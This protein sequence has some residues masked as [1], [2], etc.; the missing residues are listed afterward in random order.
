MPLHVIGH[1]TIKERFA[2]ALPFNIILVGPSGVGKRRL[3]AYLAQRFARPFDILSLEPEEDD[4]GKK[5]AVNVKQV[6]SCKKF[7]ATRPFASPCKIVVIN[8]T[9][10]TNEAV[11]ALLR[12]L[13]ESSDRVRFI[14]HTSGVLPLTILS[15]CV[16]V[17]VAPLSNNEVL[18][19]LEMLG[20]T[21]DMAKVSASLSKGSVEIALS[22][23]NDSELR[24]KVLSV[25]QLMVHK[26]LPGILVAVR[27][28]GE[29]EI[30]ECT[31][32][33]EDLLLAPFGR[34]SSYTHK[35]LAIG[36]AFT[37][38]DIDRYLKL[39]HT[40]MKPS[41]KMAYIAIRVMETV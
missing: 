40:P 9:L 14:I 22:H 17:Q 12:M 15:R 6:R 23:M 38:E 32:W 39:L 20:F 30:G 24:R 31:K 8:A 37:A 21:S 7:V 5:K 16:K 25:V 19:V 11:Q 2:A 29:A 10:I 18:E 4:K 41:L 36:V 27:K 3:A 33:F 34:T 26:K 28:W 13:E 1:E 35:E